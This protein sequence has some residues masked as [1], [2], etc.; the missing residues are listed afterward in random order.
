MR[1]SSFA[2]CVFFQGKRSWVGRPSAARSEV[3]SELKAS[4][5]IIQSSA[6]LEFSLTKLFFE[7]SAR[8]PDVAADLPVTMG[9]FFGAIGISVVHDRISSPPEGLLLLQWVLPAM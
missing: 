2:P 9:L 6:V 7:I 8:H 5:A 1:P 3:S 4:A